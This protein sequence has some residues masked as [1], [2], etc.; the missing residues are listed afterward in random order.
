ML[1]RKQLDGLAK[2]SYKIAEVLVAGVAI[3]GFMHDSV[4]P[5]LGKIVIGAALTPIFVILGLVF[6]SGDGDPP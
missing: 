6:D 1:N 4:A 3:A 2:F 5:I